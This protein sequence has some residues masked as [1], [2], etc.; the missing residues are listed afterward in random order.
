MVAG[1]RSAAFSWANLQAF[2]MPEGVSSS[3]ELLDD[4]RSDRV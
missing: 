2:A 4:L 3:A 1:D